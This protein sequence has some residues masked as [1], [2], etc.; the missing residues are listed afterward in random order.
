MCGGFI[1]ESDGRVNRRRKWHQAGRD[2][3]D[4]LGAYMLGDQAF[5]RQRVWERDQGV[6]AECGPESMP[7]DTLLNP[8]PWAADHVVPVTDGGEWTLENAQTLCEEHHKA[9]SRREAGARAARARLRDRG[10][11]FTEGQ[12]SL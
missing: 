7:C 3:K 8:R 11:V 2:F 9:K 5:F 10:I 12:L 6:C 1:T 4:C